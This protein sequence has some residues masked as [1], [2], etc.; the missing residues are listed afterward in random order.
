M[1][2]GVWKNGYILEGGVPGDHRAEPIH[3]GSQGYWPAKAVQN[4]TDEAGIAADICSDGDF[5]YLKV[6]FL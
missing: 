2:P 6:T 5:H 3:K 1:K 4:G